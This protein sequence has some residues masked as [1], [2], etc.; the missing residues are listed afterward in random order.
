[1]TVSV[2]KDCSSFVKQMDFITMAKKGH[3]EYLVY[4]I[5]INNLL[6][7]NTSS[8]TSSLCW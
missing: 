3:I 2:K 7:I 1:M 8:M 4:K 6:F 5:F